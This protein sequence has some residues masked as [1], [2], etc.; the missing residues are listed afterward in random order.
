MN[1]SQPEI[2]KKLNKSN[3]ILSGLVQKSIKNFNNRDRENNIN[4][5]SKTD[6]IITYTKP[7]EYK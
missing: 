7:N 2:N 6:K 5:T 4:N 1:T 3:N